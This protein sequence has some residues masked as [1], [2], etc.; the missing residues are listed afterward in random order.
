MSAVPI[1]KEGTM[2]KKQITASRFCYACGRERPRRLLGFDPNTLKT[3]CLDADRCRSSD[4]P[5]VEL[6]P[7]SYDD[8][9]KSVE[10]HYPDDVVDG[11]KKMLGKA[12]SFRATP[13]HI[14]HILR[15][16]QEYSLESLNATLLHIIEEHMKE[17]NLDDVELEECYWETTPPKK[18]KP[19]KE[20]SKPKPEPE[21]EKPKDTSDDEGEIII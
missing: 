11:V 2:S 9:M 10:E 13:A 3:Y 14:M 20:A 21:P 8:V 7:V 5:D 4:R 15:V 1:F 6:V 12:I 17:H 19:K 18:T 16:S